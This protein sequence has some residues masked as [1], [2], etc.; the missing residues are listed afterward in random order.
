MIA[1]SNVVGFRI[2]GYYSI[3]PQFEK[4]PIPDQQLLIGRHLSL[5]SDL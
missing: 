2:K 3:R 4:M 1:A 5:I